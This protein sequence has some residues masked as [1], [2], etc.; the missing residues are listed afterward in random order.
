MLNLSSLF[1][2]GK[3]DS[4]PVNKSASSAAEPV[5]AKEDSSTPP[6]PPLHKDVLGGDVEITYESVNNKTLKH[7]TQIF[8]DPGSMPD[9]TVSGK[10]DNSDYLAIKHELLS[11]AYASLYPYIEFVLSLKGMHDRTDLARAVELVV[12]RFLIRFWDMPA[13]KDHH[14]SYPWGLALHCL[15]VGCAEAEKATTWKPMSQH[16]IDEIGLIRHLGMVV[17]MNF[18]KGLF[19]DAHKL[20]QFEMTGFRDNYTVKFNPFRK[21]GNVLDFKLV[22]PKRTE[23]WGEPYE[24]P[25]KF[26]VLEFVSLYPRDLIQYAPGRLYSDLILGFFDMEGSDADKDSVRRDLT[27]LGRATQEQMILDKV[28]AY[29]TTEK[30]DT[31]PENN[32]F[33]VNDDWAAVLS[34]QFLMAIRPLDGR[35]HTKDVVKTY[36]LKEEA[37]SGTASNYEINLLYRV[38]RGGRETLAKTRS[39][40]A[41]IKMAYLEQVCSGLHEMLAQI[42][43]DEQDREAVLELCPDADNFLLDLKRKVAE[44]PTEAEAAAAVQQPVEAAKKSPEPEKE[45]PADPDSRADAQPAE[46]VDNSPESAAGPPEIPGA[47]QADAGANAICSTS[48]KTRPIRKMVPWP[49]QLQYLITH[50]RPEYSHPVTGWFYIGHYDVYV[51]IPQFYQKMTNEDFLE[52]SDWRAIAEDMCRDLKAKG[53]LIPQPITGFID[54]I[55]PGDANGKTKGAFFKLSLEQKEHDLLYEQVIDAPPLEQ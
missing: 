4:G 26:N 12:K 2:S 45:Q 38:K 54:F 39:K 52:H 24:S 33:R 53:L 29:F 21:Q 36:L 15:D 13:S 37:L 30:E 31:K 50:Y 48:G 25:G 19:H 18:V 22:Y 8:I 10:P 34:S 5:Q 23:R 27:Q 41:F 49:E 20:H 55:A 28:K 35:T 9:I 51:R 43:F 32:V 42:Y 16:G 14:H 7:Y 3:K 46:T 11:R 17:F 47:V 44:Q 1:S 40:V 6:L